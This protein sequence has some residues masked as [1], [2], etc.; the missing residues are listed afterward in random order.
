MKSTNTA[1]AADRRER[2]RVAATVDGLVGAHQEVVG[3]AARD[4]H[5]APGDLRRPCHPRRRPP[6]TF[7]LPTGVPARDDRERRRA[8]LVGVGLLSEGD[9]AVLQVGIAVGQRDVGV[10]GRRA[11]DARDEDV[12][13]VG[14]ALHQLAGLGDHLDVGRRTRRRGLSGGG[15][16]LVSGVRDGRLEVDVGGLRRLAVDRLRDEVI[17]GNGAL[18]IRAAAAVVRLHAR[19]VIRHRAHPPLRRPPACRRSSRPAP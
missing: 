5:V 1:P 4:P 10:R 12:D 16:L 6:A 3:R 17:E 7:A 19:H 11:V 14:H 13:G 2:H 15:L 8:V 18:V 9:L